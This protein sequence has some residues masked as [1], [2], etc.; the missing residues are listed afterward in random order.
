MEAHPLYGCR[1]PNIQWLY[2]YQITLGLLRVRPIHHRQR[3][4]WRQTSWTKTTRSESFKLIWLTPKD[5]MHSSNNGMPWC[6]KTA[7]CLMGPITGV[8]ES[9]SCSALC[10]RSPFLLSHWRDAA[11]KWHTSLQTWFCATFCGG[12]T[13]M[14]AHKWYFMPRSM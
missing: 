11:T 2:I 14:C 3:E 10:R 5:R 7:M 1:A 8:P 9:F 13:W 6:V 4:R 12:L